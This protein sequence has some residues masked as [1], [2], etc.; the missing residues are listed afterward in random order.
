LFEFG[1]CG[2]QVVVRWTWQGQSTFLDMIEIQVDRGDGKGFVF[3]TYDTTPNYTFSSSEA[4]T[5][6][7]GGSCSA[8]KTNAIK[9]NN[10]VTFNTLAVGA[11]TD[12]TI[13]VKDAAKNTS[14]ALAVNSFTIAAAEAPV[15]TSVLS[16]YGAD[17][18]SSI[19]AL[20]P[21]GESKVSG[22]D[23]GG[24]ILRIN[25]SVVTP[26]AQ[27]EHEIR[28]MSPALPSGSYTL[29]V[30]NGAGN[31]SQSINFRAPLNALSIDLGSLGGGS[32][33]ACAVTGSG[34]V[35]CWGDN[36]NGQLGRGDTQTSI[37]SPVAV[38]GISTALAV[39]VGQGHSCALLAGGIV[40]CWGDNQF[41]QLGNGTTTDSLVPVDVAGITNATAVSTGSGYSCAV[42]SSG[43]IKCWGN[44]SAGHLGN[45]TTT[46]SSTPVAVS[47]ITTATEVTTGWNHSC[48]LLAG[49]SV[50]CWG[51]NTY[52]QLG[53]GTTTN[54]LTPVSV[55]GISAATSVTIGE[56]HSCA[57]LASGS[58]KCWGSGGLLGDGSTIDSSTPVTVS[59]ITT[60]TNLATGMFLNCAVLA[61]GTVK[62]WGLDE[63]GILGN[64][65]TDS[66]P[67][68]VIITG[69][70]TAVA[71]T[72]SYSNIC[73]Q[74]TDGTVTCWG[75]P[76]C[77]ASHSRCRWRCRGWRRARAHDRRPI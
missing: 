63:Y 19:T 58:V 13:K 69:I 2:G 8:S 40:K 25:G 44:N 37:A 32:G 33:T 66:V 71:V 16:Q 24:A 9:G 61:N 38:Q 1:V 47:G 26:I 17:G 12:C 60:A 67:L 22:F 7:Y 18:V 43:T 27:N 34:A 76:T 21:G 41:G 51:G 46:D 39:S 6:V 54:S 52:G 11:Y 30:E 57:L 56:V 50:K 65:T 28:F 48:A 62:C 23:L 42:L 73:A 75:T 15:I 72:A 20:V 4:G 3:L 70:S 77:P 5:I 59:G 31:T 35:L 53:D 74:M 49:G 36:T 55:S 45:G 64:G 10:T 14:A 68:P 29:E